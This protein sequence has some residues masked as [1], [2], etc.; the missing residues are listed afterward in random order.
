MAAAV[1]AAAA[2]AAR[3]RQGRQS[4]GPPKKFGWA[5]ALRH[6]WCARLAVGAALPSLEQGIDSSGQMQVMA[7]S[8][9]KSPVAVKQDKA[10]PR[11][12]QRQINM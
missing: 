12:S 10:Q 2:T 6:Q 8:L 3:R 5:R 7:D 9:A 1:G 4:G 11:Y